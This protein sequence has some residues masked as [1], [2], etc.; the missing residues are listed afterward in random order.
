MLL[1]LTCLYSYS[2]RTAVI[3]RNNKCDQCLTLEL[4]LGHQLVDEEPTSNLW[5]M[6]MDAIDIILFQHEVSW[7]VIPD[8]GRQIGH[9]HDLVWQDIVLK[10]S[11][12]AWTWSSTLQMQESRS[13]RPGPVIWLTDL[14]LKTDTKETRRVDEAWTHGLP[15]NSQSCCAKTT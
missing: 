6:A 12:T 14:S 10:S 9:I 5:W 11:S 4:S 1:R 13:T 2:G 7:E 3:I 8:I 15:P